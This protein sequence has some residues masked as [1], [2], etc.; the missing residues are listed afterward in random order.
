MTSWSS[1]FPCNQLIRQQLEDA[2]IQNIEFPG[3]P[4]SLIV[5]PRPD[6]VLRIWA[7]ETKV[8]TDL[9]Q[10]LEQGL[11]QVR[12]IQQAGRH[13][14]LA[15]CQ[16][17]NHLGKQTKNAKEPDSYIAFLLLQLPELI[18][19]YLDIDPAYCQRLKQASASTKSVLQQWLSIQSQLEKQRSIHSR[20]ES[21]M[22]Q[23]RDQQRRILR[24][25][26]SLKGNGQ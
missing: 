1:P 11:D 5:V 17:P 14:V 3:P 12:V 26:I 13:K 19:T 24:L 2:D 8:T 9:L 25:L 20:I 10:Q 16:I 6:D 23:Q 15:E 7:D 22:E 18:K 4:N 21:L